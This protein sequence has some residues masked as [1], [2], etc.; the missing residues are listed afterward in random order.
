MMITHPKGLY[1]INYDVEKRLVF[2]TPVG[3]WT[4][5]DYIEY[6]SQYEKVIG[7]AMGNKPWVSAADLRKYKMSDL[8]EVMAKHAD[9]LAEN[10]LVATASIVDSAIVKMQINR[11]ISSK[12]PQQAFLN[13]E[14][15]MTW[16]MAKL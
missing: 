15:A 16:L 13:E 10:N 3:S 12:F 14:E 4:K 11:A 8:G 7:P 9:W 5:E 1:T 2:E 6:H